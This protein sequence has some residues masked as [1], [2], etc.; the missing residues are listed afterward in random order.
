MSGVDN[1]FDV[2]VVGAGH[3]GV[4]AA[5]AASKM[6]SK[7][8]LV[9]FDLKRT[10]EMP[11][12]PSI[13][14]LGKG[15]IVGEIA[16]LGGLMPKLC[17][18]TYLQARMLNT[19]K[20][21]AVQGLRL[22]ID[23]PRYGKLAKEELEKISA[24]FLVEGA[25]ADIFFSEKNGKRFVNGIGLRDGRKFESK[26]IVLTT[27]TSLNACI[28]IGKDKRIE[29]AGGSASAMEISKSLAKALGIE[30]GRLKT[31]TPPRLL[32]KSLDFS[33]MEKQ[34]SSQLSHLF[35]F[36]PVAV[37]EKVPCFITHTNEKTHKIISENFDRSALFGGLIE[38][39]GPRYCP[40]IEDKVARFPDRKSHHVFVEPETFE[41][42]PDQEEIY[43]AGLSTSLPLDVQEAYI[44]SITGFEEAIITK[45]GYA[46]EYDFVQPNNLK[47]TLECKTVDGL[48]LAG[49][50]NGTTGYEEAAAQGLVA[51]VNASLK[52]SSEE[53]FILKRDESYIGV[54]INDITTIGVDEPYRMFT[55]RAERRLLLRN[56]NVFSRLIHYGKNLG[57]IGLKLFDDFWNEEK[58]VEK[59]LKIVRSGKKEYSDLRKNLDNFVSEE[60]QI[61]GIKAQVSTFAGVHQENISGRV[62]TRLH[63][64]VLYGGYLQRE[65]RDIE[66]AKKLRTINIPEDFNYTGIPGLSVELQQKLSMHRPQTIEHAQL[67]PGMTPSALFLLI[68][69]VTR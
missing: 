29:G 4:E 45:P 36:Y 67:I 62:V 14:G 64:E 10:A 26:N 5:Y 28:Y 13:G 41:N 19:K 63:A 44:K 52:S 3:A 30:L 27:G 56:D 22:Q 65:I 6:V 50:I 2:I 57:L 25:V 39:I 24:L 40:S 61:N 21:P 68:S 43:P 46:I 66:R 49:Q 20:G 37:E 42:C 11:C 7:V 31:G 9:T 23:K 35:E 58:I 15:H 53:E 33:K 38:G 18:E 32:K 16:A 51:G 8:L 59:C 12:N 1:K 48:F 47:E 69:Q 17:E 54:M 55:S 34:A 60:N